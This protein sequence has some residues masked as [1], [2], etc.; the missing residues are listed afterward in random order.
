MILKICLIHHQLNSVIICYFILCIKVF[1]IYINTSHID[2]IHLSLS[3]WFYVSAI[4]VGTVVGTMIV[5]TADTNK[6]FW[7]KEKPRNKC[8]FQQS[9][10]K[11]LFQQWL[12]ER[13][14]QQRLLEQGSTTKQI[15]VPTII[16]E[17]L[18]K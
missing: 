1:S 12:L 9:L 11:Q 18:R 17:T 5:E 6:G 4:V 7:N 16:V 14:F 8:L 15:F 3:F 2:T 13:T 10:L